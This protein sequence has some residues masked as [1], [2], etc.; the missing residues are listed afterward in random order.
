MRIWSG[1][2]DGA[3]LVARVPSPKYVT[4]MNRTRGIITDLGSAASHM[5]A[6]ARDFHVPT[7]LN[8]QRATQ[9]LTPGLEVTVD[10]SNRIVYQGIVEN[11]VEHAG[12]TA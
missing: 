11:L 3:I 5:A 1:F 8:T 10:A 6:L 12:G 9:V 2:P 4:V 7:I